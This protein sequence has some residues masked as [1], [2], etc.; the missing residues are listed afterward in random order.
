MAQ[1]IRVENSMQ[2]SV[3]FSTTKKEDIFIYNENVCQ[4]LD[5]NN[6]NYVV[7]GTGVNGKLED[8]DQV[9]IPK[10]VLIKVER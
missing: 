9:V 4:R 8:T 7:L 2:V 5:K 6:P 3:N 10:K 1:I